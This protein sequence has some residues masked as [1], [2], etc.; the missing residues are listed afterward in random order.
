MTLYVVLI[1][2]NPNPHV[3]IIPSAP[4]LTQCSNAKYT[5]GIY[6]GVQHITRGYA[7]SEVC[8]YVSMLSTKSFSDCRNLYLQAGEETKSKCMAAFANQEP[9]SGDQ[10]L[11]ADRG[12]ENRFSS[13]GLFE[14]SS[15]DN[16]TEIT[17]NHLDSSDTE[18]ACHGTGSKISTYPLF[19]VLIEAPCTSIDDVLEKWIVDG[20][21]LDRGE[22]SVTLLNLQKRRLYEK[23]LQV[24]RHSYQD[25]L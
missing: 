7:F 5:A 4:L 1:L 11:I 8:L 22:I 21:I 14:S 12:N 6:G 17:E 18:K 13:S 25:T 15:V 9:Q 10:I 3:L 16:L 23:A 19:K 2:R 24:P 20:N